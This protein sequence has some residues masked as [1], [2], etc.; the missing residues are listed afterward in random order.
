MEDFFFQFFLELLFLWGQWFTSKEKRLFCF[1]AFGFF[2]D[3][4]G[5]HLWT[6][7]TSI[8]TGKLPE[9]KNIFLFRV[10]CKIK[11]SDTCV[12]LMSVV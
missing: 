4:K 8:Y 11:K 9:L 6:L 3:F 10:L 2:G 12:T 1:R 5:V 7:D